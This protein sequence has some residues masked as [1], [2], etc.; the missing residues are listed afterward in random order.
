MGHPKI[1]SP[2]G[3]FL[4]IIYVGAS[5][6]LFIMQII[7]AIDRNELRVYDK[8]IYA[9]EMPI[10]DVDI[11]QLYFAFALE[12]PQTSNRFIDESIYYAKV[13]FIDKVKK[14][15]CKYYIFRYRAM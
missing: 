15:D 2:F 14:N 7:R 1:G 8:T 3:L 11:N 4:T 13:A 12:D 5:I 6:V 10:I 9:Q